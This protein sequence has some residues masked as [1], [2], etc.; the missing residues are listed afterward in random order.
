MMTFAHI[1][2]TTNAGL[3]ANAEFRLAELTKL[4]CSANRYGG[5]CRMMILEIERRAA[6]MPGDFGNAEKA[7]LIEK[8]ERMRKLMAEIKTLPGLRAP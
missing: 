5:D 7:K 1:L 3:L 4:V 6:E 8:A 2:D